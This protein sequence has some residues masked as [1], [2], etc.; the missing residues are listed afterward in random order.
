MNIHLKLCN[1]GCFERLLK[2]TGGKNGTQSGAHG[3]PHRTQQM[4][5]PLKA[6]VI[7]FLKMRIVLPVY[8]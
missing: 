8:T 3:V 1:E 6:S 4:L 5:E 7:L 2:Q